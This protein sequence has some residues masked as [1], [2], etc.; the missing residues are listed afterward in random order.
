MNYTISECIAELEAEIR[1]RKFVYGA[2]VSGGKMKQAQM[3][4]KIG[5]FQQIKRD[6]EI[7]LNSGD[8]ENAPS[9]V[10]ER[11]TRLF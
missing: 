2:K 8:A 3:N 4:R 11:Q 5:I 9:D 1:M 10:S 6:Y 7:R